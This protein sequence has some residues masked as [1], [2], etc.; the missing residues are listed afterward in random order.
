MTK[1]V[2]YMELAFKLNYSRETGV[3]TWKE[4]SSKRYSGKLA[5]S[6]HDKRHGRLKVKSNNKRYS[7]GKLC[8]IKA[9]GCLPTGVVDHI[10]G[11]P[12]NNSLCNLRDVPNV[13]NARNVKSK[14]GATTFI[15][16]VRRQSINTWIVSCCKENLGSFTCLGKAIK[17]RRE[18]EVGKG[19]TDRHLGLE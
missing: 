4:N 7:Y 1:D 10:D 12:L 9:T 19:F 15:V 6:L 3:L 14:K 2:E 11:N 5:G 16:G 8:W 17:A 13:I 18:A